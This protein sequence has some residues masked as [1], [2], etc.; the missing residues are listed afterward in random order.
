MISSN[1]YQ[2]NST[3]QYRHDDRVQM[4]GLALTNLLHN[5]IREYG[6][7]ND[8]GYFVYLSDI[9]NSDRKLLI[10]HICDAED[11][12]MACNSPTYLDAIWKENEKFI[13]N[14]IDEESDQV[15]RE[16]MEEM[17]AYA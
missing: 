9:D 5:V 15:Y 6:K 4:Q 8:D 2:I 10:S 13:R 12:E 17:R 11:Y 14:L 7:Y 16:A 3:M 1:I